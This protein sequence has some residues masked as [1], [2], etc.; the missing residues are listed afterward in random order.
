MID[1]EKCIL[2]KS[3]FLYIFI[4]EEILNGTT[5][6]IATSTLSAY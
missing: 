6:L 3:Y 1:N 4:T 2:K 5:V